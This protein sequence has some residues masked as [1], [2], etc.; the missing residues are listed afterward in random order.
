M[1]EALIFASTKPQYDDRLFIDLPV[2]YIKIPNLEHG[3]T[4]GE[5][6]AYLH[7][8]FW[9]S[10]QK[11]ICVHNMLSSCSPHV[12]I[13]EFSCTYWTCNSMNNLSSY[14]GLV[15]AKIRASDKDLPVQK[16]SANNMNIKKE[17]PEIFQSILDSSQ[18]ICTMM[19]LLL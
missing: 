11:T 3:E 4:W 13:L 6:V 18:M 8:L 15:D 5:H 9:M 10:K 14:C 1:S 2:Q 12:L 19:W 17:L 16:V 7:K